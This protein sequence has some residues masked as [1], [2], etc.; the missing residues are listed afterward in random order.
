MQDIK[1]MQLGHLVDFVIDYNRR[2]KQA[3]QK[4]ETS[5]AVKHYRLATKDEVDAMFRS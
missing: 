3:E 1:R 5:H 2:Q 4:A